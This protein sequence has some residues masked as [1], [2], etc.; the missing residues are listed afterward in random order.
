MEHF[1]PFAPTEEQSNNNPN[2]YWDG[3]LKQKVKLLLEKLKE[4]GNITDGQF[5][6]EVDVVMEEVPKNKADFV[7][8]EELAIRVLE[9]YAKENDGFADEKIKKAYVEKLASYLAS[10]LQ[11]FEF[12]DVDQELQKEIIVIQKEDVLNKDDMDE[13]RDLFGAQFSELKMK[14]YAEELENP[15]KDE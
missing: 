9:L 2:K 3:F 1:E 13:L 14:Q 10:K 5:E 4:A 15:N 7:S 12:E 8:K 6:K 11:S